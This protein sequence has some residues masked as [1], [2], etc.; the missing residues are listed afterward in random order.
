MN[1]GLSRAANLKQEITFYTE[2]YP[3]ANFVDNGE[4]KGI[5]IESLKLMWNKMSQQ[6]QNIFVV[7]WARGYRNALLEP[8]TALFTMSRTEERETLFKWLGPL[9]QSRHVLIA[10]KSKNIKAASVHDLFQFRVATI[11]GDISEISLQKMGYPELNMAKVTELE[12][13]FYMMQSDR[14]ELLMVSIHGFQHLM[15]RLG[16]DASHYEQVWHVNTVGNYIA[17]N[18]NIPDV[19]IEKY[20]KAFEE[21]EKE[22]REIRVKYGMP[23]ILSD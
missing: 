11:R 9:F 18:R 15:E 6:E 21:T 2:N 17:F 8:N 22:R 12:R 5:T 20:R 7:P 19:I 14:V 10:K 23:R 4:M 13:A 1:I 3:P 16:G